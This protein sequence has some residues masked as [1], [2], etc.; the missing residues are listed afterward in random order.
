MATCLSQSKQK[1]KQR[2]QEEEQSK[3]VD[4]N[5]LDDVFDDDQAEEEILVHKH[6][7]QTEL[8]LIVLDEF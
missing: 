8:T 5:I 3:N 2:H 4:D 6:Y 1:N 7:I